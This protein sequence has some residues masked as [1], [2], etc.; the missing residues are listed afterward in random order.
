MLGGIGQVSYSGLTGAHVVCIDEG[1]TQLHGAP[2]GGG[3]AVARPDN[4]GWHVN[5]LPGGLA[6]GCL[7]LFSLVGREELVQI[8]H[9]LGINLVCQVV[10]SSEDPDVTIVNQRRVSLYHVLLNHGCSGHGVV[11]DLQVVVDGL[12]SNLFAQTLLQH[13]VGHI[14]TYNDG[15]ADIIPHLLHSWVVDEVQVV[16]LYYVL[17]SG[18]LV[19]DQ[20]PL[21]ERYSTAVD[22]RVVAGNATLAGD[23][24]GRLHKFPLTRTLIRTQPQVSGL[25]GR[26]LLGCSRH[27]FVIR[28]RLLLNSKFLFQSL[29]EHLFGVHLSHFISPTF[30]LRPVAPFGPQLPHVMQS[31][32]RLIVLPGSYFSAHGYAI[33]PED[34]GPLLGLCLAHGLAQVAFLI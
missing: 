13:L 12:R 23:F 26:K 8:D 14:Q 6:Y 25:L 28:K 22:I 16:A 5:G 29:Y 7:D 19:G 17:S 27:G 20:L 2:P 15:P 9:I 3:S 24:L 1:H 10:V 34:G 30:L 18:E 31:I 11:E 21:S 33:E 32:D 4:Y